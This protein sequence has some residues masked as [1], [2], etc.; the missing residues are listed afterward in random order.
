MSNSDIYETIDL[1]NSTCPNREERAGFGI[2]TAFC[3]ASKLVNNARSGEIEEIERGFEQTGGCILTF[4]GLRLYSVRDA[5]VISHA[6][7]GCSAMGSGYRENMQHIPPFLDRPAQWEFHWLTTNLKEEDIVFGGATKLAEAIKEADK[8]YNPRAIF[9]MTSC[10]SGIIGDDIEGTVHSVQ[11]DVNAKIVPVHCEGHRSRNIQTS[12]D[13][14]WHGFL[15]YLIKKPEKKQEDLVNVINMFSY[16]WLDFLEAKR[17]LKKMG[18]RANL[19]PDFASVEDIEVMSEAALTVSFCPTFGDYV[20]KGLEQE[21]G[22]PYFRT[23]SPLGFKN[24]DKWLR[25]IGKLTGREEEAEKVMA[26]E[27]EKWFPR[28]EYLREKIK[29]SKEDGSIPSVIGALG[30]GRM[31]THTVFFKELGL[32]IS[33]SLTLDYDGLLVEE[34]DELIKEVGDFE[35][36]VNTFQGAD[37]THLVRRKDPDVYLTCPFK[38]GAYKRGKGLGWIHTLRPMI[39]LTYPRIDRHTGVR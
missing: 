29:I 17:L 30:Q 14:I 13:A 34:L 18:L 28:L 11:P 2:S 26:E 31:L 35:I 36:S 1:E 22:V 19:V 27:H 37:Q 32:D 3:K 6:P 4:T 12:Y 8:R 33:A 10:A 16:T 38:G 25:K 23:P 24:T 9:I 20:M 15:K 5:V 7:I 39:H 21:Y